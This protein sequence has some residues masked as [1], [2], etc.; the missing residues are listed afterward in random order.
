MR[1]VHLPTHTYLV[2]ALPLKFDPLL[3]KENLTY[4]WQTIVFQAIVKAISTLVKKKGNKG[5]VENLIRPRAT[6][7]VLKLVALL[8]TQECTIPKNC[9]A[10][11]PNFCSLVFENGKDAV[12][13]AYCKVISEYVCS[14]LEE[15]KDTTEERQSWF[16]G[17]LRGWVDDDAEKTQVSLRLMPTI[18]LT[19]PGINQTED[20]PMCVSELLVSILEN[21]D[22]HLRSLKKSVEGYCF[23]SFNK[24]QEAKEEKKQKR[25][26]KKQ[27]K[28]AAAGLIDNEA[29][30]SSASQ[31]QSSSPPGRPSFNDGVGSNNDHKDDKNGTR[32]GTDLRS[33]PDIVCAINT[34]A[35]YEMAFDQTRLQ[36]GAA[37][38]ESHDGLNRGFA[39]QLTPLNQEFLLN[40]LSLNHGAV[41]NALVNMVENGVQFMAKKRFDTYDPSL[42]ASFNDPSSQT[43]RRKLNEVHM[44]KIYV[45]LTEL[46]T[47]HAQALEEHFKSQVAQDWSHIALDPE[48]GNIIEKARKAHSP[49]ALRSIG[50]RMLDQ[51]AGKPLGNP[52]KGVDSSVKNPSR[53]PTVTPP[54]NRTPDS[55]TARKGLTGGNKTPPSASTPT[56]STPSSSNKST[57]ASAVKGNGFLAAKGKFTSPDRLKK[58][59]P[60]QTSKK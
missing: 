14:L 49:T 38:Q 4:R 22:E 57:R 54:S 5:F 44:G 28:V 43:K 27:G 33:P 51:P 12:V 36:Y 19:S 55:S 56:S 41:P 11:M 34:S 13:S 60:T 26:T 58:R 17:S 9:K 29:A 59:S 23:Q 47:S 45:A 1:A 31:D 10:E 35:P 6:T 7:L 50:K 48:A 30:G 24:Q 37:R 32:D 39:P 40:Q 18:T 16:P 46:M 8:G 42:L 3:C 53:N 15:Q 20:Q 52:S 21:S 2:S 25:E